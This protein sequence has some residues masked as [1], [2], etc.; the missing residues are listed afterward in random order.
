MGFR[1]ITTFVKPRGIPAPL[2][3]ILFERS[4]PLQLLFT[5]PAQDIPQQ[6]TLDPPASSPRISPSPMQDP[7]NCCYF[8]PPIFS[9]VMKDL[10]HPPQKNPPLDRKKE[11]FSFASFHRTD[12]FPFSRCQITYRVL[13]PIHIRPGLASGPR[14]RR[15]P[16]TFLFYTQVYPSQN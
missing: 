15:C 6:E 7:C 9:G 8:F 4:P 13:Y 10:H 1:T 14:L 11:V 12:P 2:F 16:L 5:S 3:P